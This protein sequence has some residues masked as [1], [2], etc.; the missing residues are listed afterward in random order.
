MVKHNKPFSAPK[1][2]FN[3]V[4]N[5]GL[6]EGR[7]LS[8]SVYLKLDIL[9]IRRRLDPDQARAVAMHWWV[10]QDGLPVEQCAR[11]K[12]QSLTDRIQQETRFSILVGF[13]VGLI[14]MQPVTT[15]PE[16]QYE[17]NNT[18][19]SWPTMT[20]SDEALLEIP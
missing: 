11:S 12:L 4:P 9:S 1:D 13:G 16:V 15:N 14:Q 19:I 20:A 18:I 2:Q 10:Y 7:S 5:R 8:G 17:P 6:P 3:I